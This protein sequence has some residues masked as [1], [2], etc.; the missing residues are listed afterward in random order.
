MSATYGVGRISAD[1]ID[2]AY[3]LVTLVAPMLGLDA[4]RAL[5]RN[6]VSRVTHRPD[7]DNVIIAINPRGYVQGL[8]VTAVRNHAV[9]GPILDVPIMVIA[10]AAD[11]AG[12]AAEMLA[13]L[14]M[15]GRSEGCASMRIWTS[16]GE[17]RTRQLSDREVRPWD[18]GVLV[19]LA[20]KAS[21]EPPEP[22]QDFPVKT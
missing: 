19:Q 20:P 10:S 13:Y 16:E 3:S 5:C 7:L 15:L 11:E 17:N 9:H 6:I 12:V 18:H 8:C 21:H 4:W 14:K 22:R 2:Q 1:Q